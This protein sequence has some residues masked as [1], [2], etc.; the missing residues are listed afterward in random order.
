MGGENGKT[1]IDNFID[2]ISFGF[3]YGRL[4]IFAHHVLGKLSSEDDGSVY[5]YG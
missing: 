4:I 2:T 1:A 3:I 5:V